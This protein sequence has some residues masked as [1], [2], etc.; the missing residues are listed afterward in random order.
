MRIE[1]DNLLPANFRNKL[2]LFQNQ[3]ELIA[4][5]N[6]ELSNELWRPYVERLL[7]EMKADKRDWCIWEGFYHSWN[8]ETENEIIIGSLHM[9]GIAYTRGM[10][11][12]DVPIEQKDKVQNAL[13]LMIQDYLGALADELR[14]KKQMEQPFTEFGAGKSK[15]HLCSICK[16]FYSDEEFGHGF[17][18]NPMPV[19]DNVEARCCDKCNMEVVLQAR[20]K[21]TAQG[22]P[23]Y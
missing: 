8:D 12:K 4:L 14:K 5:V 9:D 22:L 18:N 6:E 17:G 13:K 10:R 23:P 15:K 21:R 19:I 16:R 3:D 20:L 2:E 7:A 1:L 11:V